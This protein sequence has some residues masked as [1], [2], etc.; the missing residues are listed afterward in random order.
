[1]TINVNHSS[2]NYVTWRQCIFVYCMNYTNYKLC[3]IYNVQTRYDLLPTDTI[4][5]YSHHTIIN[6]KSR[7]II[8]SHHV[9][10][11]ME[12]L[13]TLYLFGQTIENTY[14]RLYIRFQFSDDQN[15]TKT[16][17]ILVLVL[18]LRKT[19]AI[20]LLLFI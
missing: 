3:I 7:P 5:Y 16:F 13:R 11:A 2:Y 18:V 14:I 1:M 12:R 8:N 10:T 6:C 19:L 15:K 4:I 20:L 17:K 9:R